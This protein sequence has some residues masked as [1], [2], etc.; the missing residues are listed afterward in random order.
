MI[1][2]PH[3]GEQFEWNRSPLVYS[4]SSFLDQQ[5]MNEFRTTN[6]LVP[7]ISTEKTVQTEALCSHYESIA[8]C[9]HLTVLT[10]VFSS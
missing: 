7:K 2:F 4:S 8:S 1:Q 9:C 5:N 3:D 10:N 6:K